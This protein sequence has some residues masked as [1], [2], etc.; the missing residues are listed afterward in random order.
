[1]CGV[2]VVICFMTTYDDHV[3]TMLFHLYLV[4]LLIFCDYVMADETKDS[5]FFLALVKSFCF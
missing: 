4:C 5:I 3:V 2:F 1:M